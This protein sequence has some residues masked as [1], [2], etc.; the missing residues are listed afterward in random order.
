[1]EVFLSVLC[2]EV[3]P[4][5]VFIFFFLLE[6][7][8]EPS[9]KVILVFFMK[10]YTLGYFITVA[11]HVSIITVVTSR[12]ILE[13]VFCLGM[14]TRNKGQSLIAA[15]S[16]IDISCLGHCLGLERRFQNVS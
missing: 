8:A 5:L 13:K 1:M 9:L 2:H 12:N 3:K 4:F 6:S 15:S 16:L 14:R 11:K 10:E 7:P